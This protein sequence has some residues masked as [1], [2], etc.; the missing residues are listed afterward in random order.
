MCRFTLR[1]FSLILGLLIATHAQGDFTIKIDYSLDTNNFFSSPARKNALQAAVSRFERILAPSSLAAVGPSGTAGTSAGWRVGLSHPGTGASYQ[2][3]TAIDFATDPLAGA[4]AA[5]QYG[6]AGL[7]S[8]EWILYAGGRN[9]APAGQG[10][11]GTGTNF[12]STFNDLDGP[13]HRGLIANTPLDT[14][15][16]LPVWGGGITFDSGTSWHFDTATAATGADVDFYSIALH[17]VGHT[18]GLASGWNQV[19]SDVTGSAYD[20]TETLAAYNADNGTSV[21]SLDLVSASNFHFQD[22]TYSSEIF[23]AGDPLLV[24]TVGLGNPQ[25]LLMEPIANFTPS[26]RRFEL[27][28]ADVAQLRD[29]G[30]STITAVPEPSSFLALGILATG[31]VIGR[32]RQSKR[33]AKQ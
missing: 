30:W 32:R 5:G 16:D 28:N 23:M 3:S 26:V 2:I 9:I 25:D 22:G 11:T 12:T 10:G 21:S 20:G 33:T 1:V 19:E 8:D 13:M 24:G 7:V 14:V 15:G 31:A 29:I 17:E 6:F 18:L 27:T 4:G